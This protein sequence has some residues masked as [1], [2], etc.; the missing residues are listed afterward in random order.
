MKKHLIKFIVR[1][2]ILNIT[3]LFILSCFVFEKE[4]TARA[5]IAVTL[6]DESYS[7]SQSDN[8]YTLEKGTGGSVSITLA[9]GQSV[10][11]K[12]PDGVVSGKVSVWIKGYP[13]QP[14]E[15]SL[16]A[17]N[18]TEIACFTASTSLDTAGEIEFDAVS[19]TT[20]D[21]AEGLTFTATNHTIIKGIRIEASALTVFEEV[22]IG[23]VL[24]APATYEDLSFIG[25]NING[26]EFISDYASHSVTASIEGTYRAVYA[27]LTASEGAQLKIT[28]DSANLGIRFEFVVDIEGLSLEDVTDETEFVNELFTADKNTL[29]MYAEHNGKTLY[30]RKELSSVLIDKANNRIL[31]YSQLVGVD[32]EA[33]KDSWYVYKMSAKADITICNLQFSATSSSY[34]IEDFR[35]N[36]EI[37]RSLRETYG[38][39]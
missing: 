19:L 22:K 37:E 6:P 17:G 15:L 23:D 38:F 34:S 27:S 26:N 28:D 13:E 31:F 39:I 32:K 7:F 36:E 16:I 24:T 1:A 33:D 12:L 2:V 30:K 29:T 25:W 4:Q 9:D 3:A 18:C 20:F 10:F 5:E 35:N 8:V 11:V 21:N 14:P